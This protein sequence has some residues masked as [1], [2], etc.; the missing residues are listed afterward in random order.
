MQRR[1]QVGYSEFLAHPCPPTHMHSSPHIHSRYKN[2]PPIVH[3]IE[4]PDSTEQVKTAPIQ[5]TGQGKKTKL[6]FPKLT[7]CINRNSLT[8]QS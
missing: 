7:A 1:T 5:E 6:I 8:G 2:Y 4:V 3:E